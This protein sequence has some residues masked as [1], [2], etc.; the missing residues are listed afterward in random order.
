MGAELV[1]RQ[2]LEAAIA[3]FRQALA[4]LPN[5]GYMHLQMAE[6]FSMQERFPLAEQ[7]YV[8]AQRLGETGTELH[9]GLGVALLRQE[10][11]EAAKKHLEEAVRLN[12]NSSQAE[13][14]LWQLRDE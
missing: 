5:D 6:T 7:H 13:W 9:L 8:E 14:I 3:R 10:K 2:K 11:R 1:Q 12:P 4:L